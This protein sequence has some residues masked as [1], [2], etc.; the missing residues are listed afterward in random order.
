MCLLKLDQSSYFYSG[1]RE[2]MNR[3][4]VGTK[5]GLPLLY[6]TSYVSK[7]Q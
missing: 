5:L 3:T 7:H 6:F 4:G 2:R 1:A